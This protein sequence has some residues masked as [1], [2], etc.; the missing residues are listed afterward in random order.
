MKQCFKKVFCVLMVFVMVAWILPV[1]AET[2]EGLSLENLPSH[3]V[4]VA[5]TT[6]AGL[7]VAPMEDSNGF[8]PIE[9]EPFI[10]ITTATLPRGRVGEVYQPFT[11]TANDMMGNVT[12]VVTG[13]PAGLTH[14]NGVISGIPAPNTAGWHSVTITATDAVNIHSR[15]VP[16]LISN[17]PTITPPAD[18]FGIAMK[19][20]HNGNVGVLTLYLEYGANFEGLIIAD[21]ELHFNS[22]LLEFGSAR[23]GTGIGLDGVFGPLRPSPGGEI[24][25]VLECP[26]LRRMPEG[27]MVQLYFLVCDSLSG[28]YVID[29]FEIIVRHA[30]CSGSVNYVHSYVICSDNATITVPSSIRITTTSLPD[31]RVGV[32]FEPITL[33]VERTVG[34]VTWNVSGLP[35][36]LTHSNGVISGIPATNTQGTHLITI[37]AE[38]SMGIYSIELYIAVAAPP[39]SIL[40]QALPNGQAGATFAPVTLNAANADGGIAWTIVGLPNGLMHVGGTIFGVPAEDAVGTHWMMV[41]ATDGITTDNATLRLVISPAATTPQPTPPPTQPDLGDAALAIST[42]FADPGDEVEVHIRL[43]NNPGFAS[44]FMR[45]DFPDELTLTGYALAHYSLYANFETP[46]NLAAFGNHVYMGWAGR[47]ENIIREGT[48][49]TL[50][51]LVCE[52]MPQVAALPINVS[53]ASAYFGEEVPRNANN[54]ELDIRTVNGEVRVQPAKIGDM[55]GSGRRTSAGATLLARYLVGHYVTID[56][57]AADVNCDGVVNTLDLIRFARVLVGHFP[58]LC[59]GGGCPRCL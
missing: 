23:L 40:T 1:T 55:D 53:F 54:E 32:P 6:P 18:G 21:F 3:E 8:E 13:L 28:G 16:I 43:L 9:V 35:E 26:Q 2:G 22:D 46:E 19:G 56:R 15:I 47:T 49:I 25:I 50:T 59:P 29:G 38:D 10:T 20:S 48:L 31:G 17:P 44:M 52:D 11:L 57:R 58:T 45:L 41:T 37:T 27:H 4:S 7:E 24:R 42:S 12:W 14:N 51:F 39:I 5:V 36:G 34:N 30:I 33:D